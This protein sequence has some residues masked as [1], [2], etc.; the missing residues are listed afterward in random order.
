MCTCH[1]NW[2]CFFVCLFI[3]LHSRINSANHERADKATNQLVLFFFRA[4]APPKRWT[5][6]SRRNGWSA[7]YRWLWIKHEKIRTASSFSRIVSKMMGLPKMMV[8]IF[9]CSSI[10]Y[11][12]FNGHHRFQMLLTLFACIVTTI[13]H[14]LPPRDV[15]PSDQQLTYTYTVNQQRT[16]RGVSVEYHSTVNDR[17]A[18]VRSVVDESQQPLQSSEFALALPKWSMRRLCLWLCGCLIVLCCYLDVGIIC[19]T[20]IIYVCCE[21]KF[22]LERLWGKSLRKCRFR[23]C[24]RLLFW[25][26]HKNVGCKY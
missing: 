4:H 14:G 11:T 15:L 22:Q 20:Q 21:L 10:I 9:D 18:A 7:T 12:Q 13:V 19:S 23:P 17:Y 3:R 1:Y 6:A 2:R 5:S 24:I 16:D 25:S 8:N 26:Y